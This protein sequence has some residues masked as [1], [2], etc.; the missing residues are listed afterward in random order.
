MVSVSE[1]T[2]SA[3]DEGA[4]ASCGV[5]LGK[6]F[7]VDGGG[8]D[9]GKVFGGAAGVGAAFAGGNIFGGAVTKR[10]DGGRVL[11]GRAVV[12]ATVVNGGT[13]AV[14]SGAV[15]SCVVTCLLA[16]RPNG[17][18]LGL[19]SVI[20]DKFEATDDSCS[21]RLRPAGGVFGRENDVFVNVCELE[22]F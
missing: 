15:V 4:S 16:E 2:T 1:S 9:D 17:R 18:S 22:C 12:K 14:D 6:G 21:F 3:K 20:S 13:V 8:A 10:P 7:L 11:C 19:D 5:A